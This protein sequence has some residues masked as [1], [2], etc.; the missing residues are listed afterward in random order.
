M[1]AHLQPEE[2]QKLQQ[3]LI[4]RM[5]D[6]ACLPLDMA[7]G[8][9]TAVAAGPGALSPEAAVARVLG[10]LSGSENLD[11]L[12][13]RFQ[14]QLLADLD[15]AEYGPLIMQYPRDDGTM[16]PIP[17][18]WCQGYMTGLDAMGEEMLDHLSADQQAAANV[19]PILTF[20]MYEEEQYFNPPN[21]DAHRETVDELGAC[22]V[23][24]YRWWQAQDQ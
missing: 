17:Y 23:N 8:F 9:M 12:V 22:A 10:S 18:G 1:S 16:L 2:L 5:A 21:E 24:L 3:V 19:S 4:E 13:S 7:H 6:A 20:L 14:A 11:D 15:A